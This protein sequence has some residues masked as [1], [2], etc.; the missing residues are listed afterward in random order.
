MDT[1]FGS[2]VVIL[3][4]VID[5]VG[6]IPLFVSLLR[7]VTPERRTA[8]IAREWAIALAVLLVFLLAGEGVL[9]L[10][11]LSEV[12]LRIAGGV[13]LFLIALRMIFQSGAGA[14]GALP[15]GE[16]LIVPLAVPAIAGPGAMASVIVLASHAPQRTPEWV[17]ALAVAMLATLVV[18]LF[19]ERIARRLG[20]RA[21][22]ALER[23][24]GLILTAFA[25]E[26]LLRGIETFVSQLR[27]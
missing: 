21:L 20:E 1:S 27:S 10:F 6:N 22:G 9:R 17:A 19:A 5:P 4:L 16:P 15:Q 26:M 23:L 24:L 11:G 8:V 14:F 3:L 12:S 18:L 7:G 25:I 2:A 13:I